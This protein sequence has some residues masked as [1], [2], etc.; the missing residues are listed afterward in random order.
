M[1]STLTIT[2][3][4]SF[5]LLAPLLLLVACDSTPTFSPGSD[6]GK[7]GE[8]ED[9]GEK[10]GND[11]I[12]LGGGMGGE[13]AGDGDG[14]SE[15]SECGNGTLE[16]DEVCD[17]GNTKADDGCSEDCQIQ[18][19]LFDCSLAGEPCVNTVV[20]GNGVLEGDEQCDDGNSEPGD[21]CAAAC[22]A[23]EEGFVCTRPGRSCVALS[24]CGNG[25][26]ERGEQCDDGE[27]EP[28]AG[29]G[30]DAECQAEVGFFCAVAG[31][32][33]VALECGD[34]RRTP[35]E[36]CDDGDI[37][38]GNGCSSACTVE[39]GFRCNT[40]GCFEICGDG[41]RRG[42]EADSGRC[43]DGNRTSGD[44]CSSAC[45]EEP[46]HVCAGAGDGSCSSS[47]VCG[48]GV[49]EPG[50][51]CDPPGVGGCLPGCDNFSPEVGGGAT[52]G[53][54]VIEAGETCDSPDPGQGCSNSC[55]VEE[56]FSCPQPNLCYQ[57]PKCGDG[58]LHSP[59]GETCD[60]GDD[61]DPNDGC[62]ACEVGVGF[63]C[64]GLGPSI[65]VEEVCGDAVRTPSEQCE[66]NNDV[67]GD[68]CT[69][70]MVDAGYLCPVEGEACIA[71]C[72]DGDIV[73]G[74]EGCD[75]E[76]RTNGDGCSSGCQV[77]PGYSCTGSGPG[78]C[79]PAVCG[80]SDQAPSEGCDDGNR[81]AGDGC[82]PTCQ[83]EPTITPGPDPIVDL[84][85]GD[86]LIT[87]DEACDDG[88][89]ASGDGC[90]YPDC[91]IEDDFDCVS[92]VDLPEEVVIAVTHRDFKSAEGQNGHPDFEFSWG[93]QVDGVA[94]DAC[95][96][97]N[98]TTC[99]RLDSEGKPVGELA[100]IGDND[101][102]PVYN[103]ADDPAHENPLH[104][105][106]KIRS[107]ASFATWFRGAKEGSDENVLDYVGYQGVV[108]VKEIP[109]TLTLSQTTGDEYVY[110][111]SS[112]LPLD[113]HQDAFGPTL[114]D[115]ASVDV[116]C[117]ANEV[118]SVHQECGSLG[119]ASN[120]RNFGFTTELRYF[121]QYSGGETLSFTGDDDVWV[122]VN[123][124][125]A[126]D[127]GA[128]HSAENGRVVL[129]DDGRVSGVDSSTDSD[130][131]VHGGGGALPAL[132]GC[133]DADEAGDNEDTRFGL[134]KGEIYEIVLFQAER[135]STGSNFRLTLDGF[136]APR[137]YCTPKCGDGIVGPGEVCDQGSSNNTNTDNGEPTD[138]V[139]G[140]CNT[141]C[142]GLAFCGDG[143]LNIGEECD[144]EVNRDLYGTAS[145]LCA[146]GCKVPPSCGDGIVQSAFESCDNGSENSDA[147]YGPSSC[148]TN[149][150]FGGYCGD[151]IPNG[152][153][154]CDKGED[155][156]I[157]YGLDS[158][159][160]DCKPG[161]RCGDG[162]RNGSEQC[163]GTANCNV[164]CTY[165]PFCG[166]GVKGGDEECD[167]GNF[168]SS[169]YGGCK[170][171]CTFG[172]HCGDGEHDATNEDCD[173]GESNVDDVYGA[174]TTSC[175]L[176]PHCGDKEVQSEQLEE[177]DNGFNDDVYKYTESSCGAGC[178]EPPSCGDGVVQPDHELCDAGADNSDSAYDGCT[179]SCEWGPYC[180]DGVKDPE[181]SC[182]MGSENKPY[183]ASGE[184]CGYDCLP[185][186]YCGD[187]VRNGSEQCDAGADNT[188]AYGGCKLD[189]TRAPYCGDGLVQSD[190]GEE[191]D[192]GAE[193]SADCTL[194]CRR[195]SVVK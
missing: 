79:D 11:N 151:G 119:G 115:G 100:I 34:G 102:T 52:C 143:E 114:S 25:V 44:G 39:D 152:D 89:Q 50:E 84:A 95:T 171:D 46:F 144:N 159:G 136:L 169:T 14:D 83:L 133:Y 10:K 173:D 172:P 86:G 31:E 97:A 81:V 122:F 181:E 7:S 139:S 113:G 118:R 153:E 68:G 56:G 77:E 12:D 36:E 166:D 131:S 22:E 71:K 32:P 105:A 149:C 67:D 74:K 21:G 186:P 116:G 108:H 18:D 98:R 80:D 175:K 40:E 70:C 45:V 29:D 132:G 51:I 160:Y 109:S 65:C 3:L 167:W 168:P 112:F 191:C 177:C 134:V 93:S 59:L 174:C 130:C 193:G 99:G 75:D 154:D 16:A 73:P 92:F 61:S 164:D 33:C 195:R 183:S 2:S 145:G 110:E 125:L 15:P 158:C 47:I 1:K 76:N 120:T 66:D 90:S 57:V 26:R 103:D 189:C 19:P 155:N 87:G 111:N 182:D 88:N 8:G 60:D 150:G 148:T 13:P 124:K 48:D 53:N 137:S 35:E 179:T 69:G 20:C 96:V 165:D 55:L 58:I 176:G 126:V 192:G 28:D 170:I 17:D 85:C 127:I 187:G 121:F 30:C 27:A 188:G 63:S 37:L 107:P 123:G 156:G 142:S 180:G 161:P 194:L 41:K 162:V 62:H 23:V 49:V 64:S 4:V 6:T 163:D 190:D 138:D 147:S 78:S 117:A 72:G 140:V 82:G 24:I 104:G 129:G 91:L 38:D 43:D 178:V 9:D 106:T 5:Q 54:D 141:T 94:G 184:G 146:P 135:H 157:E 101:G 42:Q 128:M 185:A